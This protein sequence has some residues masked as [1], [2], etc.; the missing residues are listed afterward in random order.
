M[1]AANAGMP[2]EKYLLYEATLEAQKTGLATKA[3][4]DLPEKEKLLRQNTFL[5]WVRERIFIGQYVAVSCEDKRDGHARCIFV[6][7]WMLVHLKQ[8]AHNMVLF[9]VPRGLL[10]ITEPAYGRS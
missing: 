6:A 5:Q 8:H 4:D 2:P 1:E 9:C 7:G 3:L 10:M